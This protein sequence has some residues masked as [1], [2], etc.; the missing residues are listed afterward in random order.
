MKK[1]HFGCFFDEEVILMHTDMEK[2]THGLLLRFVLQIYTEGKDA[3][4]E[5]VR[6]LNEDN[7]FILGALIH[8]THRLYT[9][10]E[11][12][13]RSKLLDALL[14]F[15]DWAKEAPCGTW[16]KMS[17]LETLCKMKDADALHLLSA[18]IL[19]CLREK[20]DIGDFYDKKEHR[21]IGMAA[22][23]L[24]VAA[25]CAARRVRLG[26]EEYEVAYS[27]AEQLLATIDGAGSNGYLDDHPNE[28][29]YDSY[30][31]MVTKELPMQCEE[32]GLPIPGYALENLKSVAHAMLQMANVHGD[33]FVYGR[34]LSVY[35]DMTPVGILSTAMRYGLL[36]EDECELA[37]AYILAIFNKLRCFWYDEK[38]DMFNIWLD[39]RAT[40]GYREIYRLLEVNLGIGEGMLSAI[41]ALKDL[42][43]WGRA[44]RTVIPSPNVW[45]AHT[46]HFL[47]TKERQAA[48]IILRYGD[49]LCMLPLIGSGSLS[50]FPA[51]LP[52]PAVAGVLE[53]AP[54][55]DAP[56]LVPEYEK[57]GKVFRPI[58]YYTDIAVFE[59][60]GKVRVNA[61]GYM[62]HPSRW[63]N[64]PQKTDVP[65]YAEYLFEKENISARFETPCAFDR[66]R[67]QTACAFIP[68]DFEVFGFEET[69]A[70]PLGEKSTM[71][72][73]GAY[74]ALCEHRSAAKNAV[75]W[76][77][78]LP[79]QKII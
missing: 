76:S 49:T 50:Y 73:H 32:V 14:L 22:N 2:W 70:L 19:A 10:A 65:F 1:T 36:S 18:E 53:A 48:A 5:G 77:I 4:R 59:E 43:L 20:T 75:G 29:R 25:T 68:A 52:F 45:H 42:G 17:I 58:Q 24:H 62:V 21:L 30:T 9:T 61:R 51:Y 34:S 38:R 40:D 74:T 47:D 33:G 37:Y 60:D 54:Q 7:D 35:G 28:G 26:W 23:Y 67:M 13:E 56:Y 15:F 8:A 11:G 41:D 55:S 44:P 69:H 57:D 46:F 64:R 27:I 71:A 78:R 63:P 66:V 16:G 72:P 12:E 3:E 79:E 39:G 31:F 6:L